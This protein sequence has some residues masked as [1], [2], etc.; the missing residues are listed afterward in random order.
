[1]QHT[2]PYLRR[3]GEDSHVARLL[4]QP[5]S[6]IHTQVHLYLL[7]AVFACLLTAVFACKGSG[8]WGLAFWAT[9]QPNDPRACTAVHVK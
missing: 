9:T 1:M 6:M 3:G 2:R 7:T 8:D 5:A 4:S